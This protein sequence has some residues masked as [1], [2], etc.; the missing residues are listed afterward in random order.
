MPKIVFILAECP[1][2]GSLI[3]RERALKA[4]TLPNFGDT[5][6][7]S[8]KRISGDRE[9]GIEG[10]PL[11]LMIM[12]IIAGL[13]TAVLVGWMGGLSAPQAISSVGASPSEVLLTDTDGDGTFE[14]ESVTITI[15]VRDQNGDAV[16]G[17]SVVL[18]GC[19]V[20][21][22]DGAL[23]YGTTGTDGKATF[24]GL[25]VSSSGNGIGF[26]TVTA[27]KGG[28]GTDSSLQIPVISR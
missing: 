25:T 11:Q 22:A 27:A 7:F 5:M 28:M 9:G 26:I 16:E 17:A 23:V 18:D 8:R 24:T 2:K 10:L 1:F 14:N 4:C 15:V 13:G 19:N 3:V 20:R 12:V 21:T 6:R